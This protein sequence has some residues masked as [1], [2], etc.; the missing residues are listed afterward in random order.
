MQVYLGAM[1]THIR[2]V[3]TYPDQV[4][5]HLEG[6]WHAHSLHHHIEAI[7]LT[8]VLLRHIPH[9]TFGGIVGVRR[10]D[11]LCYFQSGVVKVEVHELPG[12]VELGAEAAC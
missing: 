12:C 11:L 6:L 7:N 5:A 8:K 3:A 10:T 4:L 2:N 1:H 9:V